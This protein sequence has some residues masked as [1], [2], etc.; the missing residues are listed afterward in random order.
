M[1]HSL[2]Q[3]DREGNDWSLICCLTACSCS[4]ELHGILPK[5]SLPVYLSICCDFK[6]NRHGITF[7]EL[8][9]HFCQHNLSMTRRKFITCGTKQLL[10]IIRINCFSLVL[11]GQDHLTKSTFLSLNSTI[12]LLIT[13]I[14]IPHIS[15][16]I[17][18]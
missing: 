2:S 16:K 9:S 3:K 12:E 1:E 4:K 11:I 6:D 18:K 7:Y 10:G 15:K 8:P 14:T 13:S 5:T 17:G